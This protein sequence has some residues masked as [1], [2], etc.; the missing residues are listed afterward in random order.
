[1]I[2]ARSKHDM[3]K[4]RGNK[5]TVP[6]MQRDWGDAPLFSLMKEIA[7]WPLGAP[8]SRESRVS[9]PIVQ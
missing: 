1:M 9:V 7:R 8:L 4:Q 5:T 6:V 2:C 3:C